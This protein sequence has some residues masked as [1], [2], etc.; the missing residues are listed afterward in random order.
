MGVAMI[1]TEHL[2]LREFDAASLHGSDDLRLTDRDHEA[3]HVAT[4]PYRLPQHRPWIDTVTIALGALCMLG[5][6]G[7]VVWW[8]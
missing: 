4:E 2:I 8:W 5:M 1:Q 3:I 6:V 7:I